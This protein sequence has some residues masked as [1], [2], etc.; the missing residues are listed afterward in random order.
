VNKNTSTDYKKDCL[1][2]H[3]PAKDKDWV[4]VNE[5]PTLVAPK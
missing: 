4:Y 5:Y 3:V 1:G 2:C